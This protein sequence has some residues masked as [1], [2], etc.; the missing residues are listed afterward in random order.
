MSRAPGATDLSIPNPVN[1]ANKIAT[2]LKP[3]GVDLNKS[4]PHAKQAAG[5]L[6][7]TNDGHALFVRRAH[8]QD[9]AGEW[10]IPAG[11]TEG[12]EAP[13]QTALRECNEEVGDCGVSRDSIQL[14]DHTFDN[15]QGFTTFGA[16]VGDAFKPMLNDEHDNHQWSSMTTPPTP[17]HPGL[18]RTLDFAMDPLTNKGQ[19]IM[20][21]M[22]QQYGPEKGESVFYASANKGNIGGVEGDAGQMPA[23]PSAPMQRRPSP[24]PFANNVDAPAGTHNAN[25]GQSR[26]SPR[27]TDPTSQAQPGPVQGGSG[28][29]E[30]GITPTTNTVIPLRA[31]ASMTT[32]PATSM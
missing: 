12:D 4:P 16:W 3:P 11:M 9:H 27:F 24:T 26:G 5:T 23:Q 19:K 31:S 28:V 29:A 14:M 21:S 10:S 6:L 2:H 30:P 25:R 8:G 13:W 18:K 32:G 7:M 22:K 1:I 15:G 17:L 20:Q